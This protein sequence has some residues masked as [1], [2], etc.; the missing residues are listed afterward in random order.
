MNAARRLLTKSDLP[1]DGLEETELWC[2]RDGISGLTGIAGLETWGSQGLVRSVVVKDKHRR[3]GVGKALIT[4][5]VE[6]AST[7][8][9][10]ELYLIT[11]TTPGF[12]EKLGFRHYGRERVRGPVL[13]SE[14][15]ASAC[16]DTAPVM[17]LK[18][19]ESRPG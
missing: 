17:K 1:T 9:L 14:E 5:V 11:E 12:F 7:K 16:P 15:F 8:G 3:S 10:T 6:E 19:L 4:H 18:V 13:S 2:V